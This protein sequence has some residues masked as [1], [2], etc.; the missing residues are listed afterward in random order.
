MVM[1]GESRAVIDA[2]AEA[3]ANTLLARGRLQT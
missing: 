1:S 2:C 3:F